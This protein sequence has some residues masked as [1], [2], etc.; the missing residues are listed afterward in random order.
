MNRSGSLALF[1]SDDSDLDDVVKKNLMP[2]LDER[3]VKA[4]KE[5]VK[6][7]LRI[8]PFT[9]TEEEKDENQVRKFPSCLCCDSDERSGLD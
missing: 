7:F 3:S 4:E 9:R 2:Y 1:D 8:R 6:V 5:Y